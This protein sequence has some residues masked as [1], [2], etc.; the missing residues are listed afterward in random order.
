MAE[1]GG[2]ERVFYLNI[3]MFSRFTAARYTARLSTVEHCGTNPHGKLEITSTESRGK[4]KKL[5]ILA[6]TEYLE[7]AVK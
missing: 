6:N 5:Q 3:T 2:D 1:V 7:Q 4:W